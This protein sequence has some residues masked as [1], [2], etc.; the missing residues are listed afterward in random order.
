MRFLVLVLCVAGLASGASAGENWP[1]FRGPTADGMSD[2]RGLPVTFGENENLVWKTPIHD[3]GWSSP[4]VWGNQIWMTT[5]TGDGKQMFAVCVDLESGKVVHDILLF[6]NDEVF[7]RHPTNSYASPTPAL[8]AGRGYFHF[9]R[10]GTACLDTETGKVLW[11]RRDLESE[12]FRGPGSS[13]I[14]VDDLLFVAYDGV[15]VQFVV[16]FDKRTGIDYGTDN[17]DRMKGYSTARVIE[18]E[19]RRQLISP[20]AGSTISYDP[21]TGRELWRVRHGGMNAAARPLYGHGLVYLSAG[22]REMS[23]I[24]VRP[25]G[26][27]NVTDTH[28][29][30]KSS[31]STPKRS[32]EILLGDLLFFISDKGTASC[33]D[34][35]TGEL[36]WSERLRSEHWGSPVY[37]DG[38]IYFSTKDRYGKYPV[39]AASKEFKLLAENELESGGNASP[40]IVGKALIIRTKTHLYRFEK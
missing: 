33:V 32:S 12:D 15:D 14:I 20:S 10:Y 35:K 5:A 29:E 40:A 27:G 37:A 26:T 25:D 17:G 4:V 21:A 38:K 36:Y 13:P 22:Q 30:W 2:A 1:E 11:T 31:K 18:H 34:A 3:L 28:V 16:A 39:I 9:G 7:F 19:G 6:E 8:E 23:L 24:A